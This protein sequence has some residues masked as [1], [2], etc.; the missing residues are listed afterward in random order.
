M[1]KSTP[2]PVRLW[3]DR[4]TPPQPQRHDIATTRPREEATRRPRTES[5][6]VHTDRRFRALAKDNDKLAVDGRILGHGLPPRMINLL[7]LKKLLLKASTSFEARDA[8]WRHLVRQARCGD[9]AWVVGAVGVAMPALTRR[10]A[11][12]AAGFGQ[13]TVDLDAELLS[14]F[15]YALRHVDIDAPRVITRLISPA[16]VAARRLRDAELEARGAAVKPARRT[17]TCTVDN[18]PD[19]ALDRAVAAGVISELERDVISATCVGGQSLTDYA[20]EKGRSYEAVRLCRYRGIKSLQ[21][22]IE[23]GV[24]RKQSDDDADVI[25]EATMTVTWPSDED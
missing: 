3:S 24:L 25:R 22:A 15:L 11:D 21:D 8:V 20:A 16:F 7:E 6:L 1:C 2:A 17:T 19:I 12:L 4:A 5:S 23:A 10:A 13:S 9:P 18:H 14:G